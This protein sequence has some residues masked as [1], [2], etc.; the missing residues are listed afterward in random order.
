MDFFQRGAG[1]NANHSIKSVIA[2][3]AIADS[4]SIFTI[5]EKNSNR[6]GANPRRHHQRQDSCLMASDVGAA[7]TDP[8]GYGLC[9]P[10]KPRKLANSAP[11]GFCAFALS[12]FVLSAVNTHARGI[13]DPNIVVPLAL[14]YGGLVQLLAGMW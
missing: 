9:K 3:T 11:L 10:Y 1:Y 4:S 5:F 13:N 8:L 12:S 14:G 2:M 7:R 6:T